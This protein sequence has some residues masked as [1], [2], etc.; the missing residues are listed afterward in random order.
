MTIQQLDEAI[1]TTAP[2]RKKRKRRDYP[3]APRPI[4]AAVQEAAEVGNGLSQFSE[5]G[6]GGNEDDDFG[7]ISEHDQYVDMSIAARF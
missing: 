7:T 1:E 3:R 2:L 6:F 4:S 5:V